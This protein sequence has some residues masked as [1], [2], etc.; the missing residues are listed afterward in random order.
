MIE[1]SFQ[2]WERRRLAKAQTNSPQDEKVDVLSKEKIVTIAEK[3]KEKEKEKEE[4]TE[5][6]ENIIPVKEEAS[7]DTTT[8]NKEETSSESK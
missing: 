6:V 4:E 1:V 3:E 2:P 5:K 8:F 7:M